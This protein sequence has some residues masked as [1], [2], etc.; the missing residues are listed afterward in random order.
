MNNQRTREALLYDKLG[1][2]KVK[3]RTCERHCQIGSGEL[4][5][6]KTRKNTD[7]KLYTLVYGE[8]SSMS[9][10]PIE[11]KPFFHFWPGSKALTVG[12]WSCNF[13]CPWCQNYDISKSPQRVGQGRY[14]SP[15]V[16]MDLVKRHNCQGT[17]ISFDEPTLL[18]EYSLDVFDLARR[19]GYYN[20]YVTNGYM[21]TEALKLLIEHGLD[22][23]NIDVKGDAEAVKE[24]CKAD[25]EQVWRNARL[26]KQDDLW[27]E[28]TTLVIPGV[29]DD[30]ECLRSI[31]RRIVTE[32]GSDTPWHVT[33]YYPAYKFASTLYVPP[34]AVSS[35]EGAREIG[36]E[37]GL[38][39][40][41][42]GNVPGHPYENTHCPSCSRLLIGRY[43]FDV[44][45]YEITQDKRCPNCQAEIPIIGELSLS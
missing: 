15:K 14:I 5:F 36:M 10:N 11:K 23:M 32:L 39:Y 34:T 20:T 30:E 1:D 33:R 38:D 31:A 41:Y 8:I 28:L 27:I 44:T 21:S 24:Y 43:G 18:L 37:E 4:G 45:R 26:A 17:S 12:T 7:G 25:V 16:F 22:A 19:E 2:G 3:C 13:D 42:V 35:L 9:A 29:N 6:C 40:V